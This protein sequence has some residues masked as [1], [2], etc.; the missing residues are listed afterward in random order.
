MG[1]TEGKGQGKPC[2]VQESLKRSRRGRVDYFHQEFIPRVWKSHAEGCFPPEQSKPAV[3]QL[4][5]VSSKVSHHW[6][7][8]NSACGKSRRPLSMLLAKMRPLRSRRR[9]REKIF[10]RRSLSSYGGSLIPLTIRVAR[11]CMRSI[12]TMSP[13][14]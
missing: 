12:R 11:R 10:S 2:L 13:R 1:I 5:V 7:L 3:A 4:E 9:S 6:H 8:K 14:R